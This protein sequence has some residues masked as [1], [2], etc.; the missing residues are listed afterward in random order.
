MRP[1]APLLALLAALALS[2]CKSPEEKAEAFFQ[3][4]LALMAQGDHERAALELR[5]A[6]TWDEGRRDA[7]R[8]LAELHLAAGQEAKAFAAFSE[9]VE[10]YP[11]AT[12]VR[13]R[14]AEMAVR[15]G[16]WNTLERQAEAVMPVTGGAPEGLDAASLLVTLDYRRASST[17]DDEA[18]AAAAA[19]ARDLLDLR[20]RDGLALR[21]VLDDVMRGRDPMAAL[22]ILDAALGHDPDDLKLQVMRV[23]LLARRGDDAAAGLRLQRMADLFPDDPAVRELMTAWYVRQGDV[24]GAEGYLRAR[25]GDPGGDPS[26]F[27]ELIAFL[28]AMQ[29]A[30][31]ARAELG[32]LAVAAEASQNAP[33]FRAMRAA[34]DFRAGARA[35]AIA[36]A[37]AILAEMPEGDRANRV[38]VLLAGM[39]DAE[40]RRAEA[41]EAID[42][43]LASDRAQA[44]AL[45][46]KGRWE[47]EADRPGEAIVILR[48]ALGERPRHAD[49]LSALADAHFRAGNLGLA[50]D[51]L[52]DAADA[53]GYAPR[54]ALRYAE[55]LRRTGRDDVAR[56]VLSSARARAPLDVAVG[57]AL[58]DLHVARGDWAGATDALNGIARIGTAAAQAVAADLK[59]TILAGTGRVGE[60]VAFLGALERAGGVAPEVG[61]VHAMIR[62]GRAA[63]ARRLLD[64]ARAGR[65]DHRD[66]GLLSA[67]LHLQ[68]DDRAAAE[69]DLAR[70]HAAAPDD[71]AVLRLLIPLLIAQGR[72]P[73]AATALAA[74]LEAAPRSRALRAM[75]ASRLADA[76]DVEGALAL[77]EALYAEDG[78]DPV[79]ANNLAALLT[80]RGADPADVARAE[81]VARRLRGSSEPAFRHTWGWIAFRKGDLDEAVPALEAAA[82]GLPGHAIV[83]FHL[84]L[85]YRAVGRVADGDAQIEMAR[86]LAD[87][88]ARAL[89]AAELS[90]V[91][92]TAADDR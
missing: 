87:E 49:T 52:A 70:L 77:T 86:A 44:D 91:E 45:L 42:A 47:T 64:E 83:R 28:E 80:L 1:A 8:A 33:L 78:S 40:G 73:E 84:G 7:R 29:G 65:P 53:S 57:R 25:A 61:I 75:E 59:I 38:R 37:Q 23:S 31:A 9:F 63:E 14:I 22:P 32:R 88:R 68:A 50:A 24:A 58:A 76:G 62:A 21:V 81:A 66:L 11:D 30:D 43:V 56:Q 15:I 12:D 51:R 35:A 67:S 20:P 48:T 55:H 2:G 82:L 39:L 92:D 16:D 60:G 13:H 34:V 19:Q 71:E 17:R 85:A 6:L 54:H 90:R 4:G 5:N 79:L 72:A 18:R 74:G 89:M 27:S 3:S 26:R 69:R 10:R 41:T 46:L 36:E